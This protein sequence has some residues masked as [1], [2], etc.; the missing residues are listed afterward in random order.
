MINI[1][2]IKTNPPY[3]MTIHKKLIN[4]YCSIENNISHHTSDGVFLFKV[5]LL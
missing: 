1:P 2:L 4:N 3:D 5:T